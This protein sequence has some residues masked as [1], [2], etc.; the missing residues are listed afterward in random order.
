[1]LR[2]GSFYR[3]RRFRITS[4][5]IS[6]DGL[7]DING[8]GIVPENAPEK[9]LVI[10]TDLILGSVEAFC[11]ALLRIQ[12]RLMTRNVAVTNKRRDL[13]RDIFD[14]LS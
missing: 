9:M 3:F 1:M 14:A 5:F 7:F 13:R 4:A 2:S 10:R 6:A 12:D 11:K 8:F